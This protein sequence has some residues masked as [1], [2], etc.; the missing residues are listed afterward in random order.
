MDSFY[1]E[2]R[3]QLI[4]ASCLVI[5]CAEKELS[6]EDFIEKYNNFYYYE[7][8]DGHEANSERKKALEDLSQIIGFHKLVQEDV[9]NNVNLKDI[10]GDNR[11]DNYIYRNEIVVRLHNLCSKFNIHELIAELE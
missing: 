1:I 9:I 5:K 3:K 11:S 2:I 8:L 6:V 7:A 10:D 4:S